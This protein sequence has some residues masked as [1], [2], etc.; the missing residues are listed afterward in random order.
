MCAICEMATYFRRERKLTRS[1]GNPDARANSEDQDLWDLFMM[2]G[3][4][5]QNIR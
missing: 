1:T 5:L 4:M 2:M 3:Y